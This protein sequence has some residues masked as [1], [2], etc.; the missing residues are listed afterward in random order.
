[1]TRYEPCYATRN[2]IFTP[3]ECSQ[4]SANGCILRVHKMQLNP[5][6]KGALQTIDNKPFRNKKEGNCVGD[7]INCEKIYQFYDVSM[8]LS[9]FL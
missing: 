2:T 6:H 4:L 1:M 5:C 9:Y 3:A 7:F 8:L